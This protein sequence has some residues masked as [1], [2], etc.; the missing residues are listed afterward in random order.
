M[1]SHI[2]KGKGFLEKCL[3]VCDPVPPSLCK[4]TR[5][6][7]LR[8][9]ELRP[10]LCRVNSSPMLSTKSPSG[11]MWD[12]HGSTALKQL[13]KGAL[14]L[15]ACPSWFG[16]PDTHN[17]AAAWTSEPSKTPGPQCIIYQWIPQIMQSSSM[18][19]LFVRTLI[20][21]IQSKS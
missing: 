15:E 1:K 11:G 16:S 14:Y 19:C 5:M 12:V 4:S 10:A 13:L 20:P 9:R 7:M 8:E 18:E 21:K 17:L 6:F 3:E 2:L